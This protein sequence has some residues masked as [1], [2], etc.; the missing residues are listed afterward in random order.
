MVIGEAARLEH[1]GAA[2]DSGSFETVRTDQRNASNDAAR[3]FVVGASITP[4]PC[5]AGC[6][7]RP[8]S[9]SSTPSSM[10]RTLTTSLGS[11]SG[12]HEETVTSL[13]SSQP[14][15][16]CWTRFAAPHFDRF[17]GPPTTTWNRNPNRRSAAADRD[18]SRLS[19]RRRES[20]CL[21]RV[22]TDGPARTSFPQG[23][24][25]PDRR[26][27]RTSCWRLVRRP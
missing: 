20:P 16:R 14:S 22:E 21:L 9:K 4:L 3:P 11:R 1:I 10:T 2:L 26:V 7:N 27:W 24:T 19:S 17:F 15:K 12:S 13:R 6:S 23:S 8:T 18:R 25:S 5:A